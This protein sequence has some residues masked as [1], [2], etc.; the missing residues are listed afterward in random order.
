MT[1]RVVV[2]TDTGID[3]AMALLYLAGCGDAEIVGV[4]STFGNT[5]TA[6]AERNIARVLALVGLDDVPVA[7]GADAPLRGE[8]SLAAF[9][10]GAD[11]LGDLWPAGD[12]PR[13]M[14][15]DSAADF[16]VDQALAA[17]GELDLLLLGPLTNAALALQREPELFLAYRSVVIMGGLGPFP[18]PGEAGGIDPN[19]ANDVVAAEAVYAAPRNRLVMVGSNA[20]RRAIVDEA[21]VSTL[22]TSGTDV[23]EFCAAILEA[24]MDCYQYRWG[25][26]IS[27][28][29]DGLAAGLLVHPEWITDAW[30][31]P[32]NVIDDGG[33]PRAHAMRTADG[34]PLAFPVTPAPD[35]VAVLTADQDAFVSDFVRVLRG[36][37]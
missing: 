35:T 28:A 8:A 16:L 12:L 31:G 24:Y 10:H 9:V 1:R 32:V 4:T 27:S 22:A 29:H 19:T 20:T 11:G 3:D 2:D 25:R 33:M 7:H 37:P 6:N 30:S 15:E 5:T 26:R 21:A 34:S 18:S 36:H 14:V 23:G 13:G 17:P